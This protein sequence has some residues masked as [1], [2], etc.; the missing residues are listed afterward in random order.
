MRVSFVVVAAL[1]LSVASVSAADLGSHIRI[2]D[3]NLRE[4][5]DQGAVRS[6]TFREL[7]VRLEA[8]SVLVFVDCEWFMPSGV[9][10]H[11]AFMTVVDGLRYVRVAIGCSLSARLR[12]IMLAHELQHAL[13]I[14]ENPAVTDVDS[15]ESYYESAGF[16]DRY[17]RIDRSFETEA[18]IAVQRRVEQELSGKPMKDD[19]TQ[20][21]P[22]P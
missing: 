22:Q 14:G 19:R 12:L 6:E 7:L 1:A 13:E 20:P 8:T 18:A 17:Q 21:E 11:T 2:S 9:G 3:A 5:K 15:M 10:G 16:Q 4:L